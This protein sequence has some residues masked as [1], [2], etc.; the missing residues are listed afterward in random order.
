MSGPNA[1]ITQKGH[2]EKVGTNQ[3]VSHFNIFLSLILIDNI[4]VRHSKF[5]SCLCS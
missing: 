2:S 5:L 1:K 4:N 3:S